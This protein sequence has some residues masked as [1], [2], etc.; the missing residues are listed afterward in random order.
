MSTISHSTE[1]VTR[2]SCL[3]TED[4]PRRHKFYKFL[5]K[6]GTTATTLIWVVD[7]ETVNLGDWVYYI[8]DNDHVHPDDKKCYMTYLSD[9]QWHRG[10]VDRINEDGYIFVTK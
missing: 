7:K 4:K 1:C 2:V 9:H 3:P 8:D 6:V 5:G 10:V